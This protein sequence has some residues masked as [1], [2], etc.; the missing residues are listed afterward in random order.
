MNLNDQDKVRCAAF[1]LKKDARYWWETIM[2]RRDVATM[3]WEDFV[4]KFNLK[5]YNRVTMRA[6][7]S[8]LINL[9][10]RHVTV[11]EIVHKFDQLARLCP[12]L[13]RTEEDWVIR[14]L[15]VFRPKIITLIESGEHPPTTMADC[16][17]KALRAEYRVNQSKEE[18]T[19]FY[20]AKRA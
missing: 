8:E 3:T 7:Q 2:I 11:T 16:V 20:E 14:L 13:V 4:T 5:Y 12:T 6:K 18:R 9:R 10:Q 15:E 19:K 17:S 1:L